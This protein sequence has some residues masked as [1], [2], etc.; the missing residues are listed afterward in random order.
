M[1]LLSVPYLLRPA[2]GYLFPHVSR[3]APPTGTRLSLSTCVTSSSSDRHHV[4][5][6]QHPVT[7][8]RAPTL[9]RGGTV[10]EQAADWQDIRPAQAVLVDVPAAPTDLHRILNCVPRQCVPAPT[11]HL[12]RYRRQPANRSGVSRS[13]CSCDTMLPKVSYAIWSSTAPPSSSTAPVSSNS[14]RTEFRWSVRIP[15]HPLTGV[16]GSEIHPREGLVTRDFHASRAGFPSS[17]QVVPSGR[18]G[19]G[20]ASGARWDSRMAGNWQQRRA[21]GS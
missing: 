1:S 12:V 13:R 10:A 11:P 3:Q 17:Q 19:S 20:P 8:G 6:G 18:G 4:I 7:S 9:S 5:F 14:S 16:R 21:T 15:L 2:P